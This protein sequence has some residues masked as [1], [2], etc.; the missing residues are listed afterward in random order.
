MRTSQQSGPIDGRSETTSRRERRKQEMRDRILRASL[1]LFGRQGVEETRILDICQLADVA[2]KTFFNHFQTKSQLMR[3]IADHSL[4]QLLA[5]IEQARKRQ[6]ST[7][8]RIHHFF[9]TLAENVRAHGPM[10]REL[11]IEIVRIAQDAGN[12]TQQVVKLR[13]AFGSIVWDGRALADVREDQDPE[14]QT[15]MLM[16]AFYV[17]MFHAAHVD[18]YRLAERAVASATFLADS[19]T[20]SKGDTA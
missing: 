20:P 3:V 1:D 4:G 16:G 5:D 17:L 14:T 2:Q 7:R 15:E 13:Q 12:E 10:H 9:E 11:L 18:D 19:M 8:E 6:T